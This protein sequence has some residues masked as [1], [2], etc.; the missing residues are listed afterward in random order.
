[1]ILSN[2]IS[3]FNLRFHLRVIYYVTYARAS[4]IYLYQS[5]DV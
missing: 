5:A 4:L 3:R 1:M 2:L